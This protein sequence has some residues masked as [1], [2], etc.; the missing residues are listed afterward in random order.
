[1]VDEKPPEVLEAPAAAAPPVAEADAVVAE[2]VALA[3]TL[4]SLDVD[5]ALRDPTLNTGEL[6]VAQAAGSPP[7]A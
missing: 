3:A 5:D 2:A 7:V 4:A 1:M 6:V